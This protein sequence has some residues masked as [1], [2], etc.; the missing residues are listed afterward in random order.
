MKHRAHESREL[1]SLSLGREPDARGA[2]ALGESGPCKCLMSP[3]LS[4]NS[5]FIS[6]NC[7]ARILWTSLARIGLNI[8]ASLK[9]L[10]G[11]FQARGL[12]VRSISGAGGAEAG[13]WDPPRLEKVGTDVNDT[14]GGRVPSAS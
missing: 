4:G 5:S 10:A 8:D 1:T 12:A 2:K 11:S 13:D 14:G 9:A 6:T 7:R 3:M